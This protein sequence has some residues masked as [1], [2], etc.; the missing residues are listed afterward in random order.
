MAAASVLLEKFQQPV[1]GLSKCGHALPSSKS[2]RQSLRPLIRS[3]SRSAAWVTSD[4]D[5]PPTPS[6]KCIRRLF[7]VVYNVGV[8]W[9]L[10]LLCFNRVSRFA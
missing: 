10:N 6:S 9:S 8:R 7:A 5:S 2:E 1:R 4:M 3:R